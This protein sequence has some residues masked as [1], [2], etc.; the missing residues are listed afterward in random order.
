MFVHFGETSRV[1]LPLQLRNLGRLVVVQNNVTNEIPVEKSYSELRTG[2][3]L[4]QRGDGYLLE[5][6]G[7]S[8][9]GS[10]SS[11]HLELVEVGLAHGDRTEV[12]PLDELESCETIGVT[13]SNDVLL[14]LIPLKKVLDFGN[15]NILLPVVE[16]ELSCIGVERS[17]R[18]KTA[19]VHQLE[20]LTDSQPFRARS[21][22]QAVDNSE[23][24][25]E[26]SESKL[27]LVLEPIVSPYP[28][29]LL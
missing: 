2:V 7:R 23:F 3:Q 11:L 28:Q 29:R 22:P 18:V 19:S 24:L 27:Q 6:L 14:L 13:I 16:I 20:V 17:R 25:R 9:H 12:P 8:K 21:S 10:S 1:V 4:Q 5:F 26:R 15:L